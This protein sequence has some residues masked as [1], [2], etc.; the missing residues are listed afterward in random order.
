MIIIKLHINFIN[1]PV[2]Y[3]SYILEFHQNNDCGMKEFHQECMLCCV[4]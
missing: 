2:Q 3:I 1:L 4:L